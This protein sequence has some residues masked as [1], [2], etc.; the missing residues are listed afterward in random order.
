MEKPPRQTL[1]IHFMDG[2]TINVSFPTQTE[3]RYQRKLMIEEILKK[4]MLMIEGDG[5]IHFIPIENIKLRIEEIIL[6]PLHM[7]HAVLPVPSEL[8]G[9]HEASARTAAARNKATTVRL[10]EPSPPRGAGCG[11]G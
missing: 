3:N 4:R 2:S 6:P 10:I 11:S 5:G 9:V 8:R 1:N 7:M